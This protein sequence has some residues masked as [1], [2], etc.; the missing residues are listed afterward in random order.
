MTWQPSD[1]EEV[2]VALYSLIRRGLISVHFT[3]EGEALYE[4]SPMGIA[5]DAARKH[6][7]DL[8]L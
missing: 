8:G 5:R 1:D 3:A 6:A 7:E 4:L 2:N